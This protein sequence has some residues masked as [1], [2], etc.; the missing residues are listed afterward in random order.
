MIVPAFVD[1]FRVSS[2]GKFALSVVS[3]ARNHNLTLVAAGLSFYA[4]LAFVP[5]VLLLALSYGLFAEPETVLQHLAALTSFVSPEAATVISDIVTSLL[6]DTRE[7]KGLGFAI[8]LTLTLYAGVRGARAVTQALDIVHDTQRGRRFLA[9]NLMA[10][11]IVITALVV[12][13][14][15]LIGIGV[16]GYLETLVSGLS[17]LSSLSIKTGTWVGVSVLASLGISALYRFGPARI[18]GRRRRWITPGALAAT[19]GWIFATLLLG[20]YVANFG[21]YDALYG[22]VATMVILLVWFFVS[23]LTIL[24]GAEIDAVIDAPHHGRDNHARAKFGSTT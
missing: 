6:Q 7:K 12:C 3:R 8:S 9:A 20:I 13:T 24:M 22:A 10:L 16:L 21:R 19:A 2:F 15:A 11:A 23:A 14:G 5:F 1:H 18:P 4:F 17:K